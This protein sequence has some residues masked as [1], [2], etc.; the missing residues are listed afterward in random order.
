MNWGIWSLSSDGNMNWRI[1]SLS[2]DG[3]V[4][5]GT[6]SLSSDGNMNWGTLSVFRWQHELEDL[7]SLFRWQRE[8]ADLEC[9]KTA[10]LHSGLSSDSNASAE[11]VFVIGTTSLESVFRW[12]TLHSSLS[13]DGNDSKAH[14]AAQHTTARTLCRKVLRVSGV[15]SHNPQ[16]VG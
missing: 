12:P 15:L 2:L 14:S 7:E 9:L 3:N 4:D 6:W 8:L 10:T 1:W 5:R 11:P 16:Y 13:S